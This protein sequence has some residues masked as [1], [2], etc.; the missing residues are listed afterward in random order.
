MRG[1]KILLTIGAIVGAAYGGFYSGERMFIPDRYDPGPLSDL[2]PNGPLCTFYPVFMPSSRSGPLKL[3]ERLGHSPD[4]ILSL[5][6]LPPM[7][8][9][10]YTKAFEHEHVRYVVKEYTIRIPCQYYDD[11]DFLWSI[12][13]DAG[14]D[15]RLNRNSSAVQ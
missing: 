13:Q 10:R 15:E 1:L 4:F 7:W 14:D 3:V 2:D 11:M 12:T 6:E 8:I 9:K 5:A